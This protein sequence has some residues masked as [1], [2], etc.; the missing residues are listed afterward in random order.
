MQSIKRKTGAMVKA[1]EPM[2]SIYFKRLISFIIIFVLF[3][4]LIIFANP[5]RTHAA[6][7]GSDSEIIKGRS[8][9]YGDTKAN[10][11]V[12]RYAD[13][14]VLSIEYLNKENWQTAI[15]FMETLSRI[16]ADFMFIPYT[17]LI[18]ETAEMD[19][20][21][22]YGDYPK[23]Y[24]FGVENDK[25]IDLKQW[26]TD[27]FYEVPE[28]EREPFLL[29]V[30]EC[31]ADFKLVALKNPTEKD[32]SQDFEASEDNE[33]SKDAENSE[34]DNK[35]LPEAEEPKEAEDDWKKAAVSQDL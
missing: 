5:M 23:E 24:V 32:V 33:T 25:K 4:S 10:Y 29:W 16:K 35:K 34:I 19:T 1:Y 11:M 6:G 2:D 27:R 14:Y 13:R 31:I 8:Y 3:A 21:L 28:D 15:S 22:I 18:S 26:A 20:D 7:Y 9:S 30:D 17:F 12:I